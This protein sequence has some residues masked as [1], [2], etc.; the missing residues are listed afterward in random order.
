MMYKTYG[1][2][3]RMIDGLEAVTQTINKIMVTNRYEHVTYSDDYGNELETLVGESYPVVV[4]ESE[5]LIK[6]A[7]STDDRILDVVDFEL[8]ELEGNVVT[9]KFTVQTIF[10]DVPGEV[11]LDG[12]S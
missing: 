10:G 1:P 2:G 11:N 12:I 6:E 8:S 4:S 3:G 9:I 7:L 5:R